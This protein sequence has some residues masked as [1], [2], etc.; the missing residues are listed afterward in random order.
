MYFKSLLDGLAKIPSITQAQ[1]QKITSLY[2]KIGNKAFYKKLVKLDPEC[3]NKI[4]LNDK[5]RMIRF[6]EV[7]FIQ[8]NQYFYG[9]RN[10]T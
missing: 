6:Y 7:K 2:N 1:R 4:S 8:R 10:S 5:Q 9:K 3:K